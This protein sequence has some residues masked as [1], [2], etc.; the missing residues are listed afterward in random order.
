MVALLGCGRVAFESLDDAT[1]APVGHD[2]DGD[3]LVDVFDPC[4][5]LSGDAADEDGDGVGDACD[6]SNTTA[7]RLQRFETMTGPITCTRTTS[8][9]PGWTTTGDEWV[10]VA[11]DIAALD[12]R[13]LTLSPDVDVWVG[14]SIEN[15][16]PTMPH[17]ISVSLV[18]TDTDAYHY[19]DL[20]ADGAPVVSVNEYD[21]T[22]FTTLDARNIPAVHVG[23]FRVHVRARTTGGRTI[24]TTSGWPGETYTAQ[25]P[26]PGYIG[27]EFL[28]FYSQHLDLRYRYFAVITP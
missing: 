5:F 20:Y 27:A 16:L 4:P 15:V 8:T 13:D 23:E 2:E 21:G 17:Q 24:T 28:V 19:S 14:V 11:A 7:E 26:V 1:G 6:P 25:S 12:C 18:R 10:A 9:G 3:G 22:M